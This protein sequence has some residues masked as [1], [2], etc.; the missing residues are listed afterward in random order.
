MN[1]MTFPHGYAAIKHHLIGIMND[2]I[3]DCFANSG[4][5]VISDAAVEIGRNSI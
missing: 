2:P 1:A 5:T 3:D 4:I